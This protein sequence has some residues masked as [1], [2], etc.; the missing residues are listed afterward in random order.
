MPRGLLLLA[1]LRFVN[2]SSRTRSSEVTSASSAAGAS[3]RGLWSNGKTAWVADSGQDRLFAYDLKSRERDEE[4]EV[5]L[6]TRNRDP[7]GIWSRPRHR[8]WASFSQATTS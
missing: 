4:R 2:S 7:R 3:R 6:D 5:E 1:R 8:A